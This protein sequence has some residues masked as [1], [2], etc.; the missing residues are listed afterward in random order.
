MHAESLRTTQLPSET[1]SQPLAKLHNEYELENNVYQQLPSSLAMVFDGPLCAVMVGAQVAHLVETV[2][3]F[4][5]H[6]F[7]KRKS[8]PK[9]EALH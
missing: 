4:Y 1:L 8:I 2:Q 3:E 6:L 9:R 5:I 7:R